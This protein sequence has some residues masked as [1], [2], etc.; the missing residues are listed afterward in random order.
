MF[1]GLKHIWE[2]GSTTRLLKS[3]NANTNILDYEKKN[4]LP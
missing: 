1:L 4:N 2:G 3:N